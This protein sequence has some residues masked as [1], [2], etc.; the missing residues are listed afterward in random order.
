MTFV[1]KNLRDHP[2][3]FEFPTPPPFPFQWGK[4][5]SLPRTD[6]VGLRPGLGE[7]LDPDSDRP[8]GNSMGFF[9][10]RFSV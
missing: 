6:P 5:E 2:G 4:I 10:R 1:P 9:Q 3:L 8:L 7:V